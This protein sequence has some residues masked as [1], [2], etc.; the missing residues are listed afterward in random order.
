MKVYIARIE[1]NGKIEVID[2]KHS[3][4]IEYIEIRFGA[5]TFEEAYQAAITHLINDDELITIHLEHPSIFM[6]GKPT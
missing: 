6:V 5:N 3:T 2:G 4:N 1:R